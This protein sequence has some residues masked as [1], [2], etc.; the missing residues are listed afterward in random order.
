MSYHRKIA[1]C[2]Y[3]ANIDLSNVQFSDFSKVNHYQASESEEEQ[4]VQEEH[5]E[6][7]D[8]D[9]DVVDEQRVAETAEPSSP[10]EPK[11]EQATKSSK[12]SR[13]KAKKNQ[14]KD[15]HADNANNEDDDEIP[16]TTP[17]GGKKNKKKNKKGTERAAKGKAA[18][19]PPTATREPEPQA[20]G[21][22]GEPGE[23]IGKTT[24]AAVEP[25]APEA[26][27]EAP[28][29]ATEDVKPEDKEE[30]S[31]AAEE[32][33]ASELNPE[34]PAAVT[35][36]AQT[37]EKEENKTEETTEKTVSGGVEPSSSESSSEAPK[38]ASEEAKPEDQEETSVAAEE[39]VAS[40]PTP[41]FP[42]ALTTAAQ[43][44]EKSLEDKQP[45]EDE[46]VR[47]AEAPAPEEIAQTNPVVPESGENVAKPEEGKEEAPVADIHSS[48]PESSPGIPE[49]G[50]EASKP[51]LEGKLNIV[52]EAAPE[53]RTEDSSSAIEAQ[54]GAIPETEKH[55]TEALSAD[56]VEAPTETAP[57]EED[58]AEDHTTTGNTDSAS[59]VPPF[60]R[61]TEEESPI[62][63]TVEQTVTE[64]PVEET[65]K[66]DAPIA[67][68]S[69]KVTE[70]STDT[71]LSPEAASSE[72][73]A[74]E[75][76]AM[77]S[78]PDTNPAVEEE[79]LNSEPAAENAP[80][81]ESATEALAVEE[82]TTEQPAAESLLENTESEQTTTTEPA[83]TEK[84]AV[85]S[86]TEAVAD[87]AAPQTSGEDALDKKI[88]APGEAKEATATISTESVAEN[89]ASQDEVT[90]N[91]SPEAATISTEAKSEDKPGA[92][93]ASDEGLTIGAVTETTTL[94][95][96]TEETPAMPATPDEANEEVQ[97]KAATSTEPEVSAAS[98]DAKENEAS[99]EAEP[100]SADVL[101]LEPVPESPLE[102]KEEPST[103]P[104]A[105][106]ESEETAAQ[107]KVAQGEAPEAGNDSKNAEPEF[108]ESS[109]NEVVE[110]EN[111]QEDAVQ[112]A[113]EAEGL[114]AE[115]KPEPDEPESE[116][117][118]NSTSAV[119]TEES[120]VEGSKAESVA[121]ETTPDNAVGEVTTVRGSEEQ[122]ALDNEN[123]Q[124]MEEAAAD[125]ATVVAE[126]ETEETALQTKEPQVVAAVEDRPA[127][128]KSEEEKVMEKT[129]NPDASEPQV[130][131]PEP[132]AETEASPEKESIAPE[133]KSEDLSADTTATI[134]VDDTTASEQQVIEG[135]A[136]APVNDD[137]AETTDEKT[138]ATA[139]E[140]SAADEPLP[141]TSETGKPEDTEVKCEE[142]PLPPAEAAEVSAEKPNPL[143]AKTTGEEA[144]TEGQVANVEAVASAS[145]PETSAA[146]TSTFNAEEG[147][148]SE[149]EKA[150]EQVEHNAVDASSPK[151]VHFAEKDD[152]I[153]E[154][155]SQDADADVV[156]TAES[157]DMKPDENE[158]SSIDKTEIE[159]MEESAVTG[160]PAEAVIEDISGMESLAP[161][162]Q[163]KAPDDKEAASVPTESESEAHSEE[164]A[165]EETAQGTEDEP[166]P[167][168]SKEAEVVA[169]AE[170]KEMA[171]ESQEKESADALTEINDEPAAEE[172]E[173]P[174]GEQT[175][176][177]KDVAPVD[178]KGEPGAETATDPTTEIV[179]ASPNS[180]DTEYENAA[181][182]KPE[183]AEILTESAEDTADPAESA[184]QA[185]PDE[186]SPNAAADTT[187]EQPVS[188][189]AEE[190][191]APIKEPEGILKGVVPEPA[192]E[193]QAHDDNSAITVD[194]EGAAAEE[195]GSAAPI[196]ADDNADA[197]ADTMKATTEASEQDTPGLDG[198]DTAVVPTD[199]VESTM[200]EPG[201]P[202]VL[203]EVNEVED[204]SAVDATPEVALDDSNVDAPPEASTDEADAQANLVVEESEV[205]HQDPPAATEPV[206]EKTDEISATEETKPADQ[207]EAAAEQDGKEE[208]TATVEVVGVATEDQPATESAS[209][210]AEATIAAEAAQTED[211][212]PTSETA[213]PIEAE[214]KEETEVAVVADNGTDPEAPAEPAQSDEKAG[215]ETDPKD[216]TNI[217]E[218]VPTAEPEVKD[219]ELKDGE[220]AADVAEEVTAVPEV[221]R[222]PE[223]VPSDE[224]EAEEAPDADETRAQIG[225][226]D[227]TASEAGEPATSEEPKAEEPTPPTVQTPSATPDSPVAAEAEVKTEGT[228]VEVAESEE[229]A[230]EATVEV[231]ETGKLDPV[232]I[233]T[234]S[235][236]EPKQTVDAEPE[237][238]V[239]AAKEAELEREPE[240]KEP[241]PSHS[242]ELVE[243]PKELMVEE[244]EEHSSKAAAAAIAAGIAAAAG[245][246]ALAAAEMS[247]DEPKPPKTPEEEESKDTV[248]P[249]PGE[250][251]LT[252]KS[253]KGEELYSFRDT[254]SD[255]LEVVEC[256][257]VEEVGGCDDD[258]VLA[259][260]RE[261]ETE[262]SQ[263]AATKENPGE[264]PEKLFETQG[265]T[266][267]AT[268]TDKEALVTS[269][270][271]RVAATDG[272]ESALAAV[273]EKSSPPVAE[274][275]EAGFEQSM[276]A[277]EE[278]PVIERA[279]DKTKLLG[280]EAP[281]V[282]SLG[283]PMPSVNEEPDTVVSLTEE[284]S[285]TR[286]DD[287]A[288]APAS[289]EEPAGVSESDA[290]DDANQE[291]AVQAAAVPAIEDISEKP[292]TLATATPEPHLR[293]T[294]E[295]DLV[296]TVTKEIPVSAEGSVS[297]QDLYHQ[298]EHEPGAA[299][300]AAQ[301]PAL[302]TCSESAGSAIKDES[303]MKSSNEN[304]DAGDGSQTVVVETRNND[305]AESVVVDDIAA[306]E[307]VL[308][309]LSEETA[310]E[311]AEEPSLSAVFVEDEFRRGE[312]SNA[313]PAE[314][315]DTTTT[316]DIAIVTSD[317]GEHEVTV[318]EELARDVDEEPVQSKPLE[319]DSC[320]EEPV[321]MST[322]NPGNAAS[323]DAAVNADTNKPD[324]GANEVSE[325]MLDELLAS[326]ITQAAAV[327]D[328]TG[329]P[330]LPKP[331]EPVSTTLSQDLFPAR[332]DL[333]PV[334][335]LGGSQVIEEQEGLVSI[336]TE[337]PEPENTDKSLT[338]AGESIPSVTEMPVFV[339]MSEELAPSHVDAH[340]RSDDSKEELAQT[341]ES[342]GITSIEYA[343]ILAKE[344]VMLEETPDDPVSVIRE[345]LAPASEAEADNIAE[346]AEESNLFQAPIQTTIKDNPVVRE[347]ARK[348]SYDSLS[349]K[350]VDGD[351]AF[352]KEDQSLP[353][354]NELIALPDEDHAFEGI[355]PQAEGSQELEESEFLDQLQ[356][357]VI[358][359]AASAG[360]DNDSPVVI[361][362]SGE[363]LK[364]VTA[365]SQTPEAGKFSED[366]VVSVSQ[367]QPLSESWALLEDTEAPEP[368]PVTE[369]VA[370]EKESERP[371]SDFENNAMVDVSQ[372]EIL[373][374]V[375]LI[376]IEAR[377]HEANV[378]E[379]QLSY[380]PTVETVV[381]SD[382]LLSDPPAETTMEVIAEA[383]ETEAKDPTFEGTVEQSAALH[384]A[385]T[386]VTDEGLHTL[387]TLGT[388]A[389]PA[390][391][392]AGTGEFDR[393]IDNPMEQPVTVVGAETALSQQVVCDTSDPLQTGLEV[394]VAPIEDTGHES[395]AQP[396]SDEEYVA[397]TETAVET[398]V[399]M[400][401][402]P[403]EDDAGSQQQQHAF[404]ELQ[405]QSLLSTIDEV[406]QERQSQTFD[407]QAPIE[408]ASE[409]SATE[410][411]VISEVVILDPQMETSLASDGAGNVS[412]AGAVEEVEHL[413]DLVD[414]D[415][416]PISA[417]PEAE[418]AIN[419]EHGIPVA[420]VD[421]EE[422]LVDDSREPHNG[423][424]TD[425][426]PNEEE[427]DIQ[428]Q[429]SSTEVSDRLLSQGPVIDPL[430]EDTGASPD[431]ATQETPEVFQG[432]I[433]ADSSIEESDVSVGRIAAIALG[434]AGVAAL[435]GA[436]A[437]VA[438]EK[439]HDSSSAEVA[440]HV[441]HAK[442]L[443]SVQTAKAEQ[444]SDLLEC[445]GKSTAAAET[446]AL[447]TESEV[448]PAQGRDVAMPASEMD[449]RAPTPAVVIPDS[450]MVDQYRSQMLK[451][452]KRLA[453]RNAEETVAAAVIIYATIEALSPPASPKA[454]TFQDHEESFPSTKL[455]ELLERQVAKGKESGIAAASIRLTTLVDL[456][457]VAVKKN[458][459]RADASEDASKSSPK[460]PRRDSGFS[461]D[462]FGGSGKKRRTPEEAEQERR[463]A[464]R[465]VSDQ[466]PERRER[467]E[468]SERSERSSHR[469]R[470]GSKDVE[471]PHERSHRSSRRHSHS[472]QHKSERGPS[473]SASIERDPIAQTSDKRFFEIKNSE[474]IVGSGMR[475]TI[476]GETTVEV[477]VPVESVRAADIPKRSNTRSKY[478][479][480]RIST[481]QTRAK[482]TKTRESA[483]VD[484]GTSSKGSTTPSEDNAR[485]ARKSE[486]SKKAEDDKKPSGLKGVL[487]KIFG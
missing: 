178:D 461:G 477:E 265:Q 250:E 42:A 58:L 65:H 226:N 484:R 406:P 315:L 283:E 254:P 438:G 147:K 199:P 12:K 345:E 333:D 342:P 189:A 44:E 402:S 383:A 344:T 414:I 281:V 304:P 267:E 139:P 305:A 363:E 293:V 300:A 299:D 100:A 124:P 407:A 349:V 409:V 116:P 449:S 246:A 217:T 207:P 110:T 248:G 263:P 63:I 429:H 111:G 266:T 228:A 185:E 377:A 19:S 360:F 236:G 367:E 54:T 80:P 355:D 433:S 4:E 204:K 476:A 156:T 253:K 90:K 475:P 351:D 282:V 162:P 157:E 312:E 400:R 96:A 426:I 237:P 430:P 98:E 46:T 425:A 260:S 462:S 469:D 240:V 441:D 59:T 23:E 323:D 448:E 374:D 321:P 67:D 105:E 15:T 20:K 206:E 30:T 258:A 198:E 239:S 165:A 358:G 464:E 74:K 43:P 284:P 140:Q 384:E 129:E 78:G 190:G 238:E 405:S 279:S 61:D 259:L 89:N 343:D 244:M 308:D 173:A 241:E 262:E 200:T 296:V 317:S 47:E 390:T 399:E 158:G 379:E 454:G 451:R 113:S 359:R 51:E 210:A 403:K 33:V 326:S 148:E 417:G 56:P 465:K 356:G 41:D 393:A 212:E 297:K 466:D 480:G 88:T 470:R 134:S 252:P 316:N 31:V 371:A 435:A 38:P 468:P 327:D 459:A 40:E 463:K 70:E 410:E 458:T 106:K 292:T 453:V 209:D 294:E 286:D 115:V 350:T 125:T 251:Q 382:A 269:P 152:I 361:D 422:E 446:R 319:E 154:S 404:E 53:I 3:R 192:E 369:I 86:A 255:F 28:E 337:K 394:L 45:V 16:V 318:A 214:D 442:S 347:E 73:P 227:E 76:V 472:S 114:R 272:G 27:L 431:A 186:T 121:A 26:A 82:N 182:D 249:I 36:A 230:P 291:S 378:P 388:P 247:K 288:L 141:D 276:S 242:E 346:S 428:A 298:N 108:V 370:K 270:T 24:G 313:E 220:P 170:S 184:A 373:D 483:D 277:T 423:L 285:L 87:D 118:V 122:P 486:R 146:E 233:A 268:T 221:V 85:E 126:P 413:D 341:T 375:V 35:T 64:V 17:P 102:H 387:A 187:Q 482:I 301:E 348:Q 421:D 485:R 205:S 159:P 188:E 193:E 132:A 418:T 107:D 439:L 175:M 179:A 434:S 408:P 396:A 79:I 325:P 39:P 335:G 424:L 208:G 452:K 289:Q 420:T 69:V 310:T 243:Q 57:A 261:V 415:T 467:P 471:H 331:D 1:F 290:L 119:A 474:G 216:T 444:I 32:L 287:L 149:A 201:A 427:T 314:K 145:A 8:H 440:D 83:A 362:N 135:S 14:A 191:E 202:T 275:P 223:T 128:E 48:T 311:A 22:A 218:Q 49:A 112:D 398:P 479:L 215:P 419:V 234:E 372:E 432:R 340:V 329:E 274:R 174:A 9:Q 167:R 338:D 455:Q 37:E 256:T 307:T 171:A 320:V 11:R 457:V 478:G 72:E 164:T 376:E 481:D 97:E 196:T 389:E 163:S 194:V 273:S 153:E 306:E 225:F 155:V 25:S 219:E 366:D 368:K 131:A 91:A 235:T 295:S 137:K 336:S 195:A 447:A 339:G 142:T 10:P 2:P 460:A 391:Q 183:E 332:E 5:E 144:V 324:L 364:T 109:V 168:E 176:D 203:D 412:H 68:D 71:E 380:K 456:A 328:E 143:Q 381:A 103:E 330:F 75:A 84:P 136:T 18:S 353:A 334:N 397:E 309:K 395:A 354:S 197:D 34:I 120:A 7:L 21:E 264:A 445:Q 92:D 130:A 443:D 473:A 127:E 257:N 357:Q 151:Q 77:D 99:Q 180:A 385:D 81:Q 13:R 161:D 6:G 52:S 436:A 303:V 55:N 117:Q 93:P 401:S 29:P 278:D 352:A 133:S 392:I 60:P 94:E 66:E 232:A 245:G 365:D 280:P 222:E 224:A 177:V 160:G 172:P 386:Y 487:K 411:P 302:A 231:S 123:E 229:A 104:E 437:V 169:S 101:H 62:D 150:E 322:E 138:E 211:F 50:K 181:Q 166:N 271:D 95:P 213:E 450:A 416:E